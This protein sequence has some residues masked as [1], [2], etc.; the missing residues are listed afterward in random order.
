MRWLIPTAAP[1]H[2]ILVDAL[3]RKLF[4]NRRHFFRAGL[5][6][7][8]FYNPAKQHGIKASNAR[9]AVGVPLASLIVV[10]IAAVVAV[11]HWIT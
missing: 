4:E 1:F 7:R 6:L 8:R 10:L 3:F 9:F 11:G 5:H 2:A